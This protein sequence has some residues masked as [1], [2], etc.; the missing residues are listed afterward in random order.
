MLKRI[1]KKNKRERGYEDDW[2]EGVME[3]VNRR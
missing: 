1:D 2:G 3:V